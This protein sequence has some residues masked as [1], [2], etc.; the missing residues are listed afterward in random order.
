[1]KG[2]LGEYANAMSKFFFEDDRNPFEHLDQL[3]Q[4][5]F[6][7]PSRYKVRLRDPNLCE[8]LTE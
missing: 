7:A 8:A 6:D 4:D 3:E 2:K 1:M 5:F